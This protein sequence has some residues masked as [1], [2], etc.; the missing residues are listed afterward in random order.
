[1]ECLE[2]ALQAPTGSNRQGWEWVFVEDQA[3]KDRLAE[4][5]RRASRCTA[6]GRA[7]STRPATP[8]PTG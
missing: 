5:Y 6:P 4:I 7:P 2:L 8:A 1:M 3:K